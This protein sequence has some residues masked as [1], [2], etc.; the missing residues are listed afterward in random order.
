MGQRQVVFNLSRSYETHKIL[1][2]GAYGVVALAVHKPTGMT[3]AIKKIEP[4]HKTI[5]CLRTIREL[6][7]LNFFRNHEN[8]IGFY[9]VQRPADFDS[10]NEVYLIQEYMPTDLH[11]L[12]HSLNLLD[13]HIQYFIYQV[14]R[15]LKMIHSANVIHRDLKPLNI[16]VNSNCD[17]KICDFGLARILG[18]KELPLESK[19]TEYVATRWYRAPEIMLSLSMYSTAID[20]WSVGCIMAELYLRYPMFPGKDYKHQL[21]LIFQYLGIPQGSDYECIKLHRAR[22]YIDLLPSY[23]A[24]SPRAY[25]HNHPRRLRNFGDYPINPEGLDLM[26]RM[27]CF[28]PLRRITA[29]EALVH[30]YLRK[31][32]DSTDEPTVRVPL[33]PAFLDQKEKLDLSMNALKRHLYDDIHEITKSYSKT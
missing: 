7:L 9:D 19:L 32:H 26:T 24:V 27:L 20:L 16:L 17:V 2:E 25:F 23:Q 5:V 6:N 31:Y 8:I 33:E 30:P 28:D 29:A 13:Q 18:S 15:G 1:G 14:L 21:L 11:N 4:F 22:S 12:I 10:F 3:V